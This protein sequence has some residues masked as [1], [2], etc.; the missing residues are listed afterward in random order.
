MSGSLTPDS[1]RDFLRYNLDLHLNSL[2][3]K[4]IVVH[5]D[6]LGSGTV[7]LNWLLVQLKLLAMAKNCK[8]HPISLKDSDGLTRPELKL[9]HQCYNEVDENGD[10]LVEYDELKSYLTKMNFIVSDHTLEQLLRSADSNDDGFLSFTEFKHVIREAEKLH[11]SPLW[12]MLKEQFLKESHDDISTVTSTSIS[13]MRSMSSDYK[14]K[15][16]KR[17]HL[18]RRRLSIQED[19]S[20]VS[21]SS[22][23]VSVL[24]STQSSQAHSIED[25]SQHNFPSREFCGNCHA[26]DHVVNFCDKPC[27]FCFPPCGFLPTKCPKRCKVIPIPPLK[28]AS[29]LESMKL[30]VSKSTLPIAIPTV[31]GHQIIQR[32]GGSS[33]LIR[34]LPAIAITRPASISETKTV[35]SSISSDGQIS[36]VFQGD[37]A[38]Y[39]Q[40]GFTQLPLEEKA[41]KLKY[42]FRWKLLHQLVVD[43]KNRKVKI[44]V[45]M[46]KLRAN[47]LGIGKRATQKDDNPVPTKPDLGIR[48]PL[49]NYGIWFPRSALIDTLTELNISLDTK[50][51]EVLCSSLDARKRGGIPTY[52]L[53][54]LLIASD[55]LFCG[56]IKFEVDLI[57]RNFYWY[58]CSNILF[59][60]Y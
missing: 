13:S 1:L 32:T 10:G 51:R 57:K 45:F 34:A 26:Q 25:T 50:S 9:L 46:S 39:L 19:I 8:L 18:G 14:S 41:S 33:T 5:C 27:T 22:S 6:E 4:A 59:I 48:D 21:T 40:V 28:K 55:F 49:T 53:Y 31:L 7:A 30:K 23:V 37:I 15:V 54:A 2:E 29:V 36:S 60:T 43:L 35:A 38:R 52:E 58:Y 56:K 20:D 42:H 16:N 47:A 44:T 24:K 11:A 12:L 3:G 17:G